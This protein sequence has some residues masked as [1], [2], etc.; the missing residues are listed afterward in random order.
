[1]KRHPYYQSCDDYD[2]L[3]SFDFRGFYQSTG[4]A[5]ASTAAVLLVQWSFC[6]KCASPSSE[7]AAAAVLHFAGFGLACH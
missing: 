4:T 3:Q 1:M 2:D 6:A 7:L 5:S